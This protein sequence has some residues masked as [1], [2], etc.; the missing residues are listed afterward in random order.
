MEMKSIND[1]L[2]VIEQG[3]A[4]LKA[5]LKRMEKRLEGFIREAEK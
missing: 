1:R 2:D 5:S 3:V 4:E